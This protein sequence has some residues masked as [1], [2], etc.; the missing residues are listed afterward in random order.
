MLN[1]FRHIV[2]G[3][4][5]S[6]E[7]EQ[8]EKYQSLLEKDPN[9]V[10]IRLKLGDLYAKIGDKKTSIQEYTATAVQYANDGFLEKAIAVN[11][12]IVRLDPSKQEALDRL[13]ELYFQK[14]IV[15]DPLVQ[16]YRESKGL[17]EEQ[18]PVE[19][20]PSEVAEPP[21]EQAELPTAEPEESDYILDLGTQITLPEE[22]AERP[23]IASSITQVPLLANLSAQTHHWL[24]ENTM[25]RQFAEGKVIL[26]GGGQPDSL[27][28]V[29]DG[30]VKMLTKDKEEQDTLLDRLEKGSFLG[31]LARFIP[32]RQPQDELVDANITVVA[33]NLCAVL[34]IPK[35]AF[36][37][38]IKNEPMIAEAL[39]KEYQKRRTSDVMLARVPLFSY[40]DPIERRKIAERLT[41][42]NVRKGTPVITEGEMGDSM[43]VIKTG[44]VGIYTKL[45]EEEGVS[46]IKTD[47]ERL[48][49]ATL[50]EG[51][52]F[53]E[54]ALITKEPR[55]ATVIAL[56]DVQVLKFSIHDLAV[57]VK[58]Y[59]RIGTLLK[60]YHQQRVS[61]TLASLKSIW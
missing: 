16:K 51:D 52:F 43:Y 23:D 10:T 19:E 40:L 14:G 18:T 41:P 22:P 30:T 12:L 2:S 25:L 61:A 3:K 34:E 33:E 37:V 5:K 39:A 27:F 31:D 7:D 24:Q 20:A 8:I 57:V 6:K 28:I 42:L 15:A 59:P 47:R 1:G 53:G 9:N 38:L 46:V 50:K 44:E 21:I 60:K 58:Q 17:Q 26:P 29:L 49:L 11:K 56:T 32:D 48:H 54:Q 13:S 55:S 35:A 45:T 4:K 36:T